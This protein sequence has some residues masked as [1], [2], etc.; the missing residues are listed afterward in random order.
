MN[1][2]VHN[3]VKRKLRSASV[4]NP[5]RITV[6]NSAKVAPATFECA[7]CGVFVYEGKSAK[8]LKAL[9]KEFPKK[10]FVKE[11]IQL[12]HIKPVR[13]GKGDWDWNDY[14]ESLFCDEENYQ[15]LCSCCHKKKSAK[16]KK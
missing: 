3:F 9:K 10:K 15:P 6:K 13:E 16:D 11:K 14:I 8:N 2:K 5:A 1:R 4:Y 12:D 7:K